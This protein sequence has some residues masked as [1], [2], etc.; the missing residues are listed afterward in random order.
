M[1]VS[2][3]EV[4][5]GK[6][7]GY[8]DPAL[9]AWI[10]K[11]LDLIRGGVK[12]K[13]VL[14]KPN[15]LL[16]RNKDEA[17]TTNPVILDHVVRILK[18][19]G[20]FVSVGDSPGIPFASRSVAKSVGILDVCGRNDV[21][22]LEFNKDPVWLERAENKIVKK[23]SIARAVA[24]CDLLVNLPKL[25]THVHSVFTGCVK[26]LFGCVPGLEKPRYH[27]HFTDTNHFG[28]MLAD[29]ASMI[30]P[31]L[32]IMD[33]IIAMEG[34]GPSAG[35]AKKLGLVLASTDMLA[36]DSTACRIIGQDPLRVPHLKA[37]VEIDLGILDKGKISL[38]GITDL[39]EIKPER[40]RLAPGRENAPSGV[41]TWV[42]RIL[43]KQMIPWPVIKKN[44]CVKCRACIDV[45]PADALSAPKGEVP[46]FDY[47][48]CIRCY[49]CH[50]VCPE[51][52]I[53]KKQGFL[54]KILF[55]KK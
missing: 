42:R 53:H 1:S 11:A 52:A 6:F 25:K 26:N 34:E 28:I 33:G 48:K 35:K 51:S 13:K 19:R 9:E 54:S 14:V 18:T 22:F 36:L 16:N 32:N 15:I 50:E 23:F 8:K 17:V 5:V 20:A 2:S 44:I 40:F 10:G 55:K 4:H 3:A 31:A 45:C 38:K 27:L 49:C 46:V 37:G 30:R 41:K 43:H 12:G 7:S 29:L 47:D 39:S 21:P 24:E